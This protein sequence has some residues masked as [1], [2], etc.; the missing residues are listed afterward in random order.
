MPTGTV[1]VLDGSS[2]VG[3][4]PLVSGMA[5]FTAA[6]LAAGAHLL[7]AFYSGDGNFLP[8]SS[9]AAALTVGSSQDFAFTATGITTQAVPSGSPASYTFALDAQ[10]AQLSSPITLAVSGLPP[11][12]TASLSPAYI[13]RAA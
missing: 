2:V 5:A 3:Q 11:G 13:P 7:S 4:L 12:A 10:G 9:T 6:N 1:T 8:G